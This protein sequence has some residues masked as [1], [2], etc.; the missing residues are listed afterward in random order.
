MVSQDYCQVFPVYKVY[1]YS[2]P[3]YML[4]P[5]FLFEVD[6]RKVQKSIDLLQ[7]KGQMGGPW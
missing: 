1:V 2:K 6:C 3:G 7:V 5:S 4:S